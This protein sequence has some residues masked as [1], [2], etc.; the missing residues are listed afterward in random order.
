VLQIKHTYTF[1]TQKK[2]KTNALFT[3]KLFYTNQLKKRLRYGTFID[4]LIVNTICKEKQMIYII[5]ILFLFLP[6]SFVV[7]ENYKEE[8]KFKNKT[9]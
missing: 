2:E 5:L 4:V 8:K 7:Y 9:L 1:T 6:I 3:Y